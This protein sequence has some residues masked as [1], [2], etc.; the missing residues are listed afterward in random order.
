MQDDRTPIQGG[1]GSMPDDQSLVQ[2]NQQRMQDDEVAPPADE[3]GE[4]DPVR[5]PIEDAID[6]HPFAPRDIPSV[7]EEYID[8]AARAGLVEVRLIHGRGIG[9]QREAVRKVC[10][11]HPRVS[12]F[13]DAPT[14]RGGWGATVVRLRPT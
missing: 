5:L 14:A 1:Q 3:T 2:D 10:A 4:D 12:D 8:A 9:A 13:A 7:V 11:R 6:L